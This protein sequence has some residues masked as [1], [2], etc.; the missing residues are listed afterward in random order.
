MRTFRYV[1]F[2]VSL[3]VAV[4]AIILLLNFTARNPTGRRYSS[5]MPQYQGNSAEIGVSGERI[6][7]NDLGLPNNNELG[8]CICKQDFQSNG[9]RTCVVTLE[10]IARNRIP[11]FVSPK[12]LADSKNSRRFP[13]QAHDVEQI[14]DFAT[15]ARALNVPLWVYVR[16]NTDVDPEFRR[17]VRDTGGDVILY[18]VMPGYVDPVDQG[19]QRALMGAAVGLILFGGWEYLTRRPPNRGTRRKSP[20]KPPPDDP[21]SKAARSADAME[22]F[23]QRAKDSARRKLDEESAREDFTDDPPPDTE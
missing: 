11:D 23:N 20:R 4:V 9:C 14:V 17:I 12:F 15:A 10:S 19:A 21:F 3:T 22:S 5:E 2:G 16:V 6:L 13:F 7:A 8:Q 1:G 18:F